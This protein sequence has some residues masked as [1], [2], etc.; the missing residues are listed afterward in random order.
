MGVRHALT[1]AL[2]LA[3]LGA[4]PPPGVGAQDAVALARQY[5]EAWRAELA[6]VVA[7]EQYEQARSVWA[8]TPRMRYWRE[9]ETRTTRSDVL[10]L[11][12]PAQEAWLSFRDVFEVDGRA[13]RDREQ[14]F[15][16]LFRTSNAQVATD[17]S[18]IAN[19]SA[20]F[21]LGRV[22]RNVNSPTTAL[23]FLQS[24]YVERLKWSLDSRATRDDTRVWL[25]R[26]EQNSAPYAV[27]ERGGHPV[28]ATGRVW[29]EPGIGR[30]LETEVF[31]RGTAVT[32]RVITRYAA[33]AAENVFVPVRMEDDYEMPGRER[34]AGKAT[35]INHRRFQTGARILGPPPE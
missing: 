2:S 26:F 5:L 4:A 30:I 10:L 34:V 31:L 33:M 17:A 9:V 29:L 21:N 28:R 12:A 27:T 7:E 25:L 19:E 20:R 14:R 24:P 22:A 35:Y 18:R 1:L 6:A 8:G 23:V 16:Q 3:A 11:R 32:S 13:V 15:D